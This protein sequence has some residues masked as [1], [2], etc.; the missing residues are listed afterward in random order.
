MSN[1]FNSEFNIGFHVYCGSN[2]TKLNLQC[3]SLLTSSN[4][5]D[6]DMK[7]NILQNTFELI[8]SSKLKF[9]TI[10]EAINYLISKGLTKLTFQIF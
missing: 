3:A 9:E 5:I 8:E 1:S 4:N 6:G 7:I 2:I 10:D